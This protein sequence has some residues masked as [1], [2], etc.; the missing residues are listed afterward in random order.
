MFFGYFSSGLFDRNAFLSFNIRFEGPLCLGTGSGLRAKILLATKYNFQS[1]NENTRNVHTNNTT[2][3]IYSTIFL[4]IYEHLFYSTLVTFILHLYME[5]APL[6]W[7]T[8]QQ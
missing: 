2:Y 3:H 4:D 8:E 5:M 7:F 6:P 1:W